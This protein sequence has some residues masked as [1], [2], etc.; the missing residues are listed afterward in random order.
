[1][2][3]KALLGLFGGL[4]LLT[5]YQLGWYGLVMLRGMTGPGVQNGIGFLDLLVPGKNKNGEVDQKLRAGSSGTPQAGSFG[6]PPSSGGQVGQ[7]PG[8][9]GGIVPPG[10]LG[11]N[12]VGTPGQNYQNV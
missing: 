9:Q 8:G 11:G 6:P 1:M 5:G 4:V 7:L 3:G 12:G 10:G 2:G